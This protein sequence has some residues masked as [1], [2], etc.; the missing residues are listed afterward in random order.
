MGKQRY[1]SFMLTFWSFAFLKLRKSLDTS[2]P[3]FLCH[4]SKKKSS[5]KSGHENK[6]LKF[7][8]V[9]FEFALESKHSSHAPHPPSHSFTPNLHLTHTLNAF[10]ASLNLRN[11]SISSSDF[12]PS[13]LTTSGCVNFLTLSSCVRRNTLVASSTSIVEGNVT[14]S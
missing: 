11:T 5:H 6:Y 1:V 3:I 10:L 8:A 13:S 7:Y 12:L 2:A 14:S 9:Y 4:A